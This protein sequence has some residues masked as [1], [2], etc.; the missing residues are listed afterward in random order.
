MSNQNFYGT[1]HHEGE[2]ECINCELHGF[3]CLN[4]ADYYHVGTMGPG[5]CSGIRFILPGYTPD[6][7]ER[8][9]EYADDNGVDYNE[10][11]INHFNFPNDP[12]Y[13]QV[14]EAEQF[15]DY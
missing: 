12:E 4:C 2:S 8:M 1:I 13:S 15:A 7:K 6:V 10:S 3:P 14:D 11:D 5:F 9:K